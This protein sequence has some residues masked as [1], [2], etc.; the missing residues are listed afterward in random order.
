MVCIIG[1]PAGQPK[2]IEAGDVD[3]LEG[4]YMGYNDI[5]TLG[6]NSG[7]GI[8]SS[9]DGLIV[10]VHTNGGCNPTGTGHNWGLRIS[11]II[12]QSQTLRALLQNTLTVNI[13]G[14]GTVSKNPNQTT[15]SGEVVQLTANPASGSRFV[16]WSGDLMGSTNPDSVTMDGDKVVTATFRDCP[17]AIVAV[18][19]M[20]APHIAFLRMFR[21]EIVLKSVFRNHFEGLLA[22][23]YQFTPYVVR[24]MD[25]ST[26]YE[27]FMKYVLVYPSVFLAK[28]AVLTVQVIRGVKRFGSGMSTRTNF[29][30]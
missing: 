6:G 29:T 26:I 20:L 10:G 12:A 2:R 24:N 7:S 28:R 23:Y 18:G 14:N 9:P 4:D 15:Y 17:I 19:T 3:K 16:R 5:D 30:R 21:D 25:E 27:K 1:H 22:R 11:K 13:V 8:L